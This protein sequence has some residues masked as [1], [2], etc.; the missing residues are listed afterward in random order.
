MTAFF[1]DVPALGATTI[2]TRPIGYAPLTAQR[3]T[4]E[5]A[6]PQD[7]FLGIEEH[8]FA[9]CAACCHRRRVRCPRRK[10]RAW[11]SG[12]A[13]EIQGRESEGAHSRR[14]TRAPDHKGTSIFFGPFPHPPA[15][16]YDAK[17]T[18]YGGASDNVFAPSKE[19]E[20]SV[21]LAIRARSGDYDDGTPLA[22]DPRA[23]SR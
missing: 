5:L 3:S 12:R 20:R 17:L 23:F 6:I 13:Q 7:V 19:D 9:Q 8:V 4:A 10:S 21:A 18:E 11:I 2:D 22:L 15:L 14:G 16:T 1:R